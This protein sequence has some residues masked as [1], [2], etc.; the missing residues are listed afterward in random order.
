MPK[1]STSIK[2]QFFCFGHGYWKL[3]LS[4]VMWVLILKKTGMN[5]SQTYLRLTDQ[6]DLY[7]L[8][9]FVTLKDQQFFGRLS[10]TTYQVIAVMKKIWARLQKM[11][12]HTL[13]AYLTSLALSI[14]VSH[15][16]TLA[17]THT[18]T[19]SLTL[20]RTHTH[21]L[22]HANTHSHSSVIQVF[23]ALAFFCSMKTV[24]SSKKSFTVCGRDRWMKATKS[25]FPFEWEISSVRCEIIKNIRKSSKKTRLRWWS[26]EKR[27]PFSCAV[28]MQSNEN[29]HF[30]RMMIARSSDCY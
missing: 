6:I 23:S 13:T 7:K 18:H 22:T 8:K 9:A 10:F 19:H 11:F 5:S 27:D 3:I 17:H 2:N 21:S 30:W 15:T 28:K 20:T 4:F 24:G 12:L 1:A 26:C 29:I 14:C 16:N 25:R